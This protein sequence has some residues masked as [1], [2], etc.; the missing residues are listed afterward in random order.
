MLALSWSPSYCLIEGDNANR[1]QCGADAD[2]GFIVHGLWPQ[3]ETGYPEYC[4]SAYPARV[5]EA[6]G[7]SYF[8]IMPGMGLIGHQWRKH[9]TCTGLS[10]EAYLAATR[11]ARERIVIPGDLEPDQSGPLDADEVEAAFARANP[12]L[13]REGIAVACQ[14]TLLQEVRICLTRDFTFRECREIDADGC[15]RDD[16][17]IP[18]R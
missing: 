8:N 18:P 1:V 15:R 16:L 17:S 11:E 14:G 6:L 9:G 10:P 13:P 5:P 4:D 7:R 3:F 2:Y 12:G